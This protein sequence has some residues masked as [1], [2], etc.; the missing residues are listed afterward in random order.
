MTT[1]VVWCGSRCGQVFGPP[2]RKV[3]PRFAGTLVGEAAGWPPVAG[4][5][6]PA[7][8]V[9]GT[10]AGGAALGL[11]AAP[12]SATPAPPSAFSTPRRDRRRPNCSQYALAM[13]CTLLVA[14]VPV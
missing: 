6:P 9:A 10:G 5:C 11:Q 13:A 3:P 2:Q 7:A 8:A 14:L 4:A 1:L 12:T